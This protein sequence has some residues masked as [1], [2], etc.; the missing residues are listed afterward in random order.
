MP[1]SHKWPQ[2][3]TAM[4]PTEMTVNLQRRLLTGPRQF[5]TVAMW[6]LVAVAAL[7]LAN[8][9]IGAGRV[10]LDDLRYGRP[11]ALRHQFRPQSAGD[12]GPAHAIYR[13]QP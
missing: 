3:R 11:R 13:R 4:E 12:A 1:C 6:L 7:L 5:V 8:R 9:A 10:A 2:H